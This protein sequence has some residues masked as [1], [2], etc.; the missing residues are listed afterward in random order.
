[1]LTADPLLG[2]RWKLQQAWRHLQ[3]IDADVDAF[4]AC[5]DAEPPAYLGVLVGDFPA[6]S[7]LRSRPSHLAA[8]ATKRAEAE[9]SQSVPITNTPEAFVGAT[10]SLRGVASEHQTLIERFLPSHVDGGNPSQHM[11]AVLRDL[12]NID[13]H[14][15]YIP[16]L[17]S[18]MATPARSALRISK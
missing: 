4:L 16:C 2:C 17:S 11:L 3:S 13:K 9:L 1:M 8:R 15:S 18:G 6:Q 12:S 10:D 14:D 7:P 5:D